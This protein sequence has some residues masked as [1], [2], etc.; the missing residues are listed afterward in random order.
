MF[1]LQSKSTVTKLPD[2]YAD[3]SWAKLQAA[4]EAVLHSQ[5]CCSSQ[6]SLFLCSR[7]VPAVIESTEH[8]FAVSPHNL[9][10]G[11]SFVSISDDFFFTQKSH[12]WNR[13]N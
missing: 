5:V 11:V 9:A 12:R 2:N 4:V 8:E 13:T 10:D 7:G 6:S 1:V 3:L